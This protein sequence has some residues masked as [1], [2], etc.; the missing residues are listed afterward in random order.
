MRKL[1]KYII[2]L[3]LITACSSIKTKKQIHRYETAYNYLLNK[4]YID[5][6]YA[7]S[8]TIYPMKISYF[9]YFLCKKPEKIK[10]INDT[11]PPIELIKVSHCIDSLWKFD[12]KHYK[13]PYRLKLIK[14]LKHKNKMPVRHKI[15]FSIPVDNDIIMIKTCALY[16]N[17]IRFECINQINY[18]FRFEKDSIIEF[19]RQRIN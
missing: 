11:V 7:I 17:N 15:F 4:K 6:S 3:F 18:F 9:N 16:E 2:L 5:R 14:K 13:K 19:Y 1:H 12:R 10:V 8:D